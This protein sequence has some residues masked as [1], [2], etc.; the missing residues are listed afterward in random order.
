MDKGGVEDQDNHTPG[1]DR[2]RE[3]SSTLTLKVL[4][5]PITDVT[6]GKAI[7]KGRVSYILSNRKQDK[8]A[9]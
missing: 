9:V 5:V 6:S 8:E 3:P 7:Q 1:A 2:L 4:D